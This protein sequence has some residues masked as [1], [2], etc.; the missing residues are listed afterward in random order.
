MSISLH[1]FANKSIMYAK[2]LV[3]R[4]DGKQYTFTDADLKNLC[5]YNLPQLHAFTEQRLE[6]R[7]EYMIANGKIKEVMRE[8][9]KYHNKMDFKV[10]L[11]LGVE[12]LSI[13]KPHDQFPGIENV[14]SNSLITE[15]EFRFIYRD[16][17][18][19]KKMYRPNQSHKYS[20]NTLQKIK[21]MILRK[22][23]SEIVQA[24]P[25][26]TMIG[27]IDAQLKYR[28]LILSM[29]KTLAE[30]FTNPINDFPQ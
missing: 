5:A 13:T 17:D 7:K 21:N 16:D 4:K 18:G 10:A 20:N 11:Q 22:K 14:P 1:S 3:E 12:K 8:H 25:A 2:Y 23:G 27:Q 6:K 26:E 29:R 28:E 9:V 15:P 30:S 19:L 24:G